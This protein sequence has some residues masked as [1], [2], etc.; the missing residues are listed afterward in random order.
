MTR[1]RVLAAGL[2]VVVVAV[3]AALPLF[4]KKEST[5]NL[6]ILVGLYV[7]LASSWK[8]LRLPRQR[9]CLIGCT[10]STRLRR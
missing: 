4:V 8:K 3:L 1:K 10:R 2:V 9:N 5:I 7:S 6:A